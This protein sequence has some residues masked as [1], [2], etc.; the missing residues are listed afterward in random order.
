MISF[1]DH[2]ASYLYQHFSGQFLETAVVFPSRRAGLYLRKSL[3]KLIDKPIIMPR[4]LSIE[5]FISELSGFQSIDTVY[6]QFELYDV[7][8]KLAGPKAQSF[9]DFIQ[10][11][12][13]VL[14]EFNE[15]DL[16]MADH[17]QL[18]NYLSESK[19]ISLWNPDGTPLTPFQLNYLQFYNSLG[20]LYDELRKRLLEK[21]Q[22][23][24]GL[25]YRF[26]AEKWQHE[27]VSMP[28]EKVVLA[29]FSALTSAEEKI[30]VQLE[31][32]GKGLFFWDWDNYYVDDA[33]Q[34]A[35][36]FI[37]RNKKI[38]KDFNGI[39][40]HDHFNRIPKEIQIIGVPQRIGQARIA[41][42]ILKKL[43]PGKGLST[44]TAVILND[45]SL[46][47][48]FLNS[49]P[50]AIGNFNITMGLSLDQTPIAR[51][52][53]KVMDMHE[54]AIKFRRKE[55]DP[56]RFYYKDV[57]AV[58]E[59][60]FFQQL[61]D[62]SDVQLARPVDEIRKSNS[63]FIQEGELLI[64]RQTDL[65]NQGSANLS[66]LF[67]DLQN[68]PVRAVFAFKILLKKLKELFSV[69]SDSNSDNKLNLEYLFHLSKVINTLEGMI[70]QHE[71]I[72]DIKTLR[73][74]YK[75]VINSVRLP[76]Y[77]EPLQGIQVMGMLESRTLDFENLILL[78]VNEGHLPAGKTG[79]SFI[80]VDIKRE[81]GIP[82]YEEHNAVIAYHFYR[83][84]QRSK[85]VYL[86]YNTEPD[87]MGGGDKSR[88][89]MQ[90]L[91]ELPVKSPESK[92]M[93]RIIDLSSGMD[94]TDEA[95]TV[96]KN[97]QVYEKL[98]SLAK[99]GFSASSLNSYRRCSLQFYFQHVEGIQ[100]MEE[101]EETIEVNTLGTVIHEVLNDMYK[102][103]L[104]LEISVNAIQNM[105]KNAINF[106]RRSFEKNYPGGD[107]D[108]GKNLLI[109]KVAESYVQNFLNHE[110]KQINA[111]KTSLRIKGLEKRFETEYKGLE[112]TKN[113]KI[114][115]KGFFD[116]IDN[117][118]GVT[119]II[120]YKT[121]RVAP[122]DLKFKSWHLLLERPNL[123]KSF[124]L[125]FYKYLF[126]KENPEIQNPDSG[127][128]SLRNLSTGFMKAEEPAGE[129]DEFGSFK[130]I[131]DHL[132]AGIFDVE[133]PFLQTDDIKVCGY[134]LFKAL[135][136]R[137]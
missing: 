2:I 91:H 130:E 59:N 17:E 104:E 6:L 57:L 129:D 82:V 86:L 125:L 128:I 124:Q 68:Q 7:Y 55:A 36:F 62:V 29:G 43:D 21:R 85:K 20:D 92:I 107:I 11:G 13:V 1:I 76:F 30:F 64:S 108:H 95:I 84:L 50:E 90:L 22:P 54:N 63:V 135:C 53:N 115:L 134:C 77:G 94:I 26:L 8:R 81:F 47:V 118:N 52:L 100:E 120:D 99:R 70:H 131:L 75:Q 103:Y 10:W 105:K 18:F 56:I 87:D 48:P 44:N 40:E 71:F 12:D 93:E 116:R 23:Y 69:S 78:A 42:G 46:A 72:Q 16:A 133:K 96:V 32:E 35:G 111:E 25:A 33:N 136:N 121:G 117:L 45:E 112:E 83:L 106:I 34:E 101:P 5:D 60:P 58:I 110:L 65:F 137:G 67:S 73:L 49:L 41:G 27:G 15:L 89:L 51:L 19:A 4:V 28:W 3:S 66:L 132:I 61:F 97:E 114:K 39:A 88:F 37:R 98:K 127:I 113:I 109:L 119:R 79:N 126:E 80:P 9:A 74:V 31:N 102:P 14:K 122:L 38:F 24:Q 123:D